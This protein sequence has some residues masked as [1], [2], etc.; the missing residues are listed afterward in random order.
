MIIGAASVPTVFTAPF[1]ESL[2]DA[3]KA[4]AASLA[5]QA[6]R[7]ARNVTLSVIGNTEY[8]A[9]SSVTLSGFR[10]GEN[11]TFILKSVRHIINSGGFV[12][13]LTL[14]AKS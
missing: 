14:E 4:K 2:P 5:K 9:G 6:A 1:M 12:S 3:A 8:V 13:E 10:E 11:G 7:Q